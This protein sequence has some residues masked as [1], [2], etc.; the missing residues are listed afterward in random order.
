MGTQ[1]NSDNAIGRKMKSFLILATT[2]AFA[3]QAKVL[4]PA[5]VDPKACPN[6]PFC[7]IGAPADFPTP[8]VNGEPLAPILNTTPEQTAFWQKSQLATSPADF[9]VPV[10]DNEPVAPILNTVPAQTRAH[11]NHLLISMQQQLQQQIAAQQI[12]IMQQQQEIE[13]ARHFGRL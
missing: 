13:A 9:P 10:I 3:A 4:I 6:Y 8:V 11:E 12:Q 1:F 2:M 7:S 5:G